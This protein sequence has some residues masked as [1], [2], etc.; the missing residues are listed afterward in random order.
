MRC[1]VVNVDVSWSSAGFFRSTEKGQLCLDKAKAFTEIST[2]AT[3]MVAETDAS[4]GDHS[5]AKETRSAVPLAKARCVGGCPVGSVNVAATKS[6]Q[7]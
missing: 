2:S 3:L 6:L 7:R 1:S 5:T 4:S